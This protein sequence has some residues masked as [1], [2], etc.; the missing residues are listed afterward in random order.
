MD[1]FGELGPSGFVGWAGVVGAVWQWNE[2]HQIG[3]AYVPTQANGRVHKPRAL[4]L[5]W[6]VQRAIDKIQCRLLNYIDCDQEE[7]T[8]GGDEVLVRG[9]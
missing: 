1:R 4:R 9:A 8:Q 6:A 5:M 3:F 2:E 7:S